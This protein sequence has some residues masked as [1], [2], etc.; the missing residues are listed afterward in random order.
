[1]TAPVRTAPTDAVTLPP[2]T[3]ALRRFRIH[4]A[5]SPTVL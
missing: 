2:P 1:M 3:S 5:L 4:S